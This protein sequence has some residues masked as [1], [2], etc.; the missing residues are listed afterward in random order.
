MIDPWDDAPC[1]FLTTS[2]D[3]TV[4]AANRRFLSWT[5]H[6]AADLVGRRRFQ[7]L[8]AP[9]DRIFYETHYGP[10]LRLQGEVREIA[11]EFVAADGRRL[12]AL[13]SATVRRDEGEAGV[14]LTA[15]FEAADRRA[16]E[17]ELLAARRRAE[18]SEARARLLAETLQESL[19]P[20]A[21]PVIPFL[22]VGAAYRPAGRGDEVGG[23]F[24]DVFETGRGDWAVVLGDVC[25]KGARA[26][27]V[28]ALAR[29]TVR[30]S[31]MRARRPRHVLA[32]L[33]TA[34]LGQAPERFCTVVYGRV[35]GAPGE[36]GC[37]LT[38]ASGGH[39]L[40]LR[41]S[42][43]H[44][45]DR[46]GRPGTLLGVLASPSLHDTTV[47]LVPGDSV[48]F[49]TDGV[50]EARTGG[51]GRFYGEERLRDLLAAHREEDAATTAAAV[52]HDVLSAQDGVA[53]DDVAVVVLRVPPG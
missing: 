10:L 16:Y 30:A 51:R 32:A 20:P 19:I 9:G 2:L 18:A 24:Y 13:V 3:G 43:T 33:N 26:A 6:R 48:T 36:R 52:V 34:L 5:G 7:Q 1:G 50:T 8:L 38:V 27:A 25:G 49:F 4:L 31:A 12:P 45:P 11:V 44:G 14:V 46:I 40:P 35:R 47:R 37:R 53:S 29:H 28:T 21:P 41:T 15:V 17:R 22:D 39:P 42:P 23:D